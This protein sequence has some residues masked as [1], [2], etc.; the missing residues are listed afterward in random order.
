MTRRHV[1]ALVVVCSAVFVLASRGDAQAPQATTLQQVAMVKASNPG[2]FDHFGEGGA[3]DGHI[4]ASVALS[5]DGTTLAVGAQHESSSARGINGNQNDDSAYGSGAVY[6]F[7][8]GGAN[9]RAIYVGRDA[10]PV[11]TG[12][13]PVDAMGDRFDLPIPPAPEPTMGDVFGDDFDDDFEDD[14]ERERGEVSFERWRI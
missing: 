12:R 13:V 7:T 14:V 5:G 11:G 3:L 8:G 10:T 2:M 4:G 9:Y 1:F 6:V